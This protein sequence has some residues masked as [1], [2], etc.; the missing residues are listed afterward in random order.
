MIDKGSSNKGMGNIAIYQKGHMLPA[1]QS[2]CID[3]LLF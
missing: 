3:R 2:G 1:S